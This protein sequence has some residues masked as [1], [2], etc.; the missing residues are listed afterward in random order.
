MW[1]LVVGETMIPQLRLTPEKRL[2]RNQN[3][4]M[5]R[6]A[7]KVIAIQSNGEPGLPRIRQCCMYKLAQHKSTMVPRVKAAHS[8]IYLF[9][10]SIPRYRDKLMSC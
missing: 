6:M 10:C 9:V 2:Q 1:L 4:W 3:G 5:L 8:E 7:L